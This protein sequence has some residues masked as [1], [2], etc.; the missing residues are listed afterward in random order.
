[1]A[2]LDDGTSIVGCAAQP[3]TAAGIAVC[4]DAFAAAGAETVTA[5]YSGDADFSSST[6]AAMTQT[7]NPG[8]TATVAASSVD[9]SVSGEGLSY[10]VTVTA[11]MPAAGTPTG[12][13][14]FFDGASTV[15]GCGAQ[16][17][18]GGTASCNVTYAGVSTHTITAMYSGDPNFIG[19]TSAVATQTINPA[20]TSTSLASSVNPSV[21]GQPV[22]ITATVS[23]N[24][25]GSGAPTGNVSFEDNGITIAGCAGEPVIGTGINMRRR[26]R[27]R[28][29]C[30]HRRLQR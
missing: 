23:V 1:M 11:V 19:S 2:F 29:G 28:R 15:A 20:S 26:I 10:I 5:V 14:A 30:D 22:T 21:T 13:F 4:D 24:A 25:P 17:L 3:V 16:P 27:C 6:S 8:A 9:P 12:S 18:V 7:I